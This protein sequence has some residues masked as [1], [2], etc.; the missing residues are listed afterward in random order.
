MHGSWVVGGLLSVVEVGVGG[1]GVAVTVAAAVVG[2]AV[3]VGGVD[4]VGGG[5][6]QAFLLQNSQHQHVHHQVQFEVLQGRVA[7]ARVKKMGAC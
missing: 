2:V 1:D 3:V 6:F 7:R 5:E 4:V